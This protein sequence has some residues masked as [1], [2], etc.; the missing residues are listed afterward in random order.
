MSLK[1][2]HVCEDC[3]EYNSN[4]PDYCYC[5]SCLESKLQEQ[6]E[7]GFK[8]GKKEAEEAI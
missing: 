1:T 6:Y 4:E 5:N 7:K 2:E 3:S 8:D